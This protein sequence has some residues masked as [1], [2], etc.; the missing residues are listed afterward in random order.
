MSKIALVTDSTANLSDELCASLNI[1]VVPL[2]VIWD[3][4]TYEDGIDIFAAEFYKKLGE[5]KTS[6]TTSQATVG[7]FMTLYQKLFDQGYDA[8]FSVLI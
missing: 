4:K 7:S 6:P 1:N 2:V 8:I 5:S 3:D